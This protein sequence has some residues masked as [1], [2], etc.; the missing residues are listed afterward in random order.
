MNNKN[1]I[2][3]TYG[4]DNSLKSGYFETFRQIYRELLENRWLTY[5]L[6]MRDFTTM[7]KQSFIGFLWIFIMPIINVGIFALLGR[8]GIFNYGNI[9]A[10]YP[11][12][13]VL[14]IS[15]WQVFSNGV[16]SCSNS[17]TNAGEMILHVNFS[18]KS[19]V[20][21]SVGK[22]IVTFLIQQNGKLRKEINES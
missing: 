4:P 16:M 9:T 19:L 8:S 1:E 3:I 11:V 2:T 18:K 7:Y 21:A 6:F 10:P 17:L 12:F 20:M 15:L 14:G 13:A 5:Q 22:S